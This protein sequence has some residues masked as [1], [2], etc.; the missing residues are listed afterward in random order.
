MS[1]TTTNGIHIQVKPTYVPER[2]NQR[3]H[4]YFFA[5]QITITNTGKEPAQ[6][7]SRHWIITDGVGKVEH[8]KGAG[9]V[10]KQPRLELCQSFEY[11]S[12]CPLPTPVGT[13]R[14]TFQMVRDDG[15][16]FEAEIAPFTLATP[17]T[18]N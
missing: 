6:L 4:M 8:V 13:M 10:G 12:F 9:V 14:G 5:Y 17:N 15:E 3:E 16:E 7:V 11:T 1:D 18:L 2:S